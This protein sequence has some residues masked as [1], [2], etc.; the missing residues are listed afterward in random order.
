MNRP[1]LSL[2]AVTA[3]LAAV[4][5]LAMV[6][7]PDEPGADR[8]AAATRL[9]VERSSALC[10]AP[11]NSELAD[12]TY[13]SY[14]PRSTG[15]PG[16][17]SARLRPAAKESTG[18]GKA[19]PVDAKPVLTPKKPGTP[20]TGEDS[21]AG[22]PAWIG[23]ARGDLAPGWT[24]QQTT[25]VSAGSGRGV[26]GVL[27]S[28]PDTDFWLP[29]ASTA[30]NRTDYV[31]LTNPDDSAAVVDIEL[32]GEDGA[33]ESSLGEDIQVQPRA[34]VP[35]LL[36]TLTDR[37]QPDLTAHV[38]VR[39]GRVAAALQATD[40]ARGADWLPPAADPAASLVLPGIPKDVTEARLIAFAPGDDADLAVRLASPTGPITPVGNETLHVKAGMTAAVDLGDITKGE[41]GS[42][43]LTPTR[44]SS[45]VV[46][47]LQ[48]VRG[49]GADRETAYIPATPAIGDRATVPDNRAEG[50][51]LSLVASGAPAKVRVTS[52]AGS[53]GGTPATQTYTVRKGATLLVEPPAPKGLKGSYALTVETLSGGPVH[54]ARTLEI[55]DDGIPMFT[56][57]TF[58]DDRGT[59]SVPK[60]EE[61][62]SVLQE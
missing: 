39:S 57:Q 11:S 4:T 44:G 42:L 5:G 45:P 55:P 3:A 23:A 10:P 60:A 19:E 38:T 17:G 25:T 36:S 35:V 13:T 46:A 21:G 62:L 2:I 37:P 12:T 32:Y 56:V 1:T 7:A 51:S 52:S 31:H 40:T 29:G 41:A 14:T 18:S 43:L 26:L 59:V 53:G 50:T 49:K 28:G 9:P 54:A 22:T 30:K 15:T 58:S 8:E 27:C 24:L 33:L 47:A 16:S 48:V 20:V 61:D 34:S 6:S